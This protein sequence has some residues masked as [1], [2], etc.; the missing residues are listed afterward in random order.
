MTELAILVG[1]PGSGKTTFF[2]AHLASTHVHV[3]KDLMGGARDKDRRQLE[4]TGQALRAGHSV[5]VDNINGRRADRAPLIALARE[6]G[7]RVV[8]Y[9]LD[10]SVKESLVR[11]RSRE[12]RARVPDVAVFVASK[13]LEAPTSAEGFDAVY[14]V[15]ASE[16]LFEIVPV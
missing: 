15:R 10:T 9:A 16:G 2:Q 13:R 5:A 12:G 4:Q 11:N 3:S 1:L 8:A 7:A 14:R 6:R